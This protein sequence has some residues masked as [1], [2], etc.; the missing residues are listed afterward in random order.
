[1]KG[2]EAKLRGMLEAKSDEAEAAKRSV[3]ELEKLTQEL[4]KR[5]EEAAEAASK[6]EE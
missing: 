3:V 2:I 1:M 4:Q 5:L 6:I